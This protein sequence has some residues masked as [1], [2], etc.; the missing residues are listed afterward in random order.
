MIKKLGLLLIISTVLWSCSPNKSI[1]EA[2]IKITSL[3]ESLNTQIELEFFKGKNHNQPSFAIWIEDLD[4]N[5]IETVFVTQSVASGVFK[6]GELKPGKWKNEP[7]NVRRPASLPFWAHKRNILANDGL[8]IP[9]A[10]TAVPDALS[11]ATPQNNF[12]LNTGTKVN[13]NKAFRILFEINQPWDSN[14]FWSNDKFPGDNNYATSLQP[15]LV[16]EATIQT[17]SEIKNYEFNLIGHSHPSGENGELFTDLN[18]ITTAK[19]I[20]QKITLTLK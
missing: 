15:A 11:G 8:Y 5:Y 3:P 18:T 7:G 14:D 17:D 4:G 2:P 12:I 1:V 19:N 16:Y 13:K 20:A 10:E 6:H 9:D